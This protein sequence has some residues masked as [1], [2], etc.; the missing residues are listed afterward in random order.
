MRMMVYDG[1][2]DVEIVMCV[3]TTVSGWCQEIE[4]SVTVILMMMVDGDV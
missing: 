4:W 3:V 2:G 1:D